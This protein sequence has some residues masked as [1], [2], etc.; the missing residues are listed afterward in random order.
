LLRK[1]QLQDLSNSSKIKVWILSTRKF[2][3][4]YDLQFFPG[5]PIKLLRIA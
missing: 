1:T 4:R 5:V 2:L 3:Y